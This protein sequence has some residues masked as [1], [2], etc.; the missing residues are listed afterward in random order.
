MVVSEFLD[1]LGACN[2]MEELLQSVDDDSF[3]AEDDY[4][5]V[6]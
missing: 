6:F 1:V 2:I 5:L 4:E 3:F